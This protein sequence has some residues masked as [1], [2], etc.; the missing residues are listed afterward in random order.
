M[1]LMMVFHPP[2][3]MDGGLY[4]TTQR[5]PNLH[6]Q[7]RWVSQGFRVMFVDVDPEAKTVQVLPVED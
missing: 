1:K 2:A 3:I 7:D 5:S 6:E 4:F